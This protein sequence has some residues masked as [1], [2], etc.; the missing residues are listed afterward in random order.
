MIMAR[1]TTRR[2][3]VLAIASLLGLGVAIPLVVSIVT[4]IADAPRNDDWVY[5][6]LATDLAA[7]GVLSLRGVTTMLVGQL[8]VAQPFLWLFGI[9]PIAFAVAGACFATGAVGASYWLARL[10]VSPLRA[11]AAV[12]LLLV[13]PAYLA[14]ATSFMTDVPSIALQYVC[15]AT[16]V[17]ALRRS[18]IPNRWLLASAVSGCIAFSFREFAIV[19]PVAVLAAAIVAEPRRTTN[20][21]IGA[22]VIGACG[23][24]YLL[25]LSL[26]PVSV[27]ETLAAGGLLRS[28]FA[29][30]S[31]SVALLP[32]A[33][34]AAATWRDRLRRREMA[35]GVELGLVVVVVRVFQWLENGDVP[36]SLMSN[37]TSRWGAPEP[38]IVV[39]GRPLLFSGSTWLV[40]GILVL[41]ATVVVAAIGAG[42]VGVFVR[43]AAR[44]RAS[45][46]QSIGSPIGIL[47]LYA[48]GIV[49]GLTIYGINVVVFDRYY[50]SLVPVAA[51]LL[52]LKPA[53]TVRVPRGSSLSERADRSEP[54]R[55]A[56][57]IAVGLSLAGTLALSSAFGLNSYAFDSARWAAGER[58]VAAGIP[59]DAID[60][61]YEWVGYHQRE[62][63]QNGPGTNPQTIYDFWWP[64]RLRC[65]IVSSRPDAPSGARL[66]GTVSY[67]LFLVTGPDEVLYLF[68]AD[69]GGCPS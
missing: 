52:L 28:T 4:G 33:I 17:V 48:V 65:G 34:V 39:G 15:L 44:S 25:K 35:I 49:G 40:V 41:V 36:Q 50:W 53:M 61:G 19:A 14:Y 26:I 22:G 56:A 32:A 31:L 68:R 47:A 20:W 7:T 16:G 13:F 8:I 2:M 18:P 60:A 3:D 24:L 23:L 58:F 5:R 69:G 62:P 12:A 11:A 42:L 29:L 66:V 45:A 63:A 10:F 67:R 43:R 46:R 38:T 55:R 37:L 51:I 64:G 6:R 30:S 57:I 59:P 1:V 27:G 54:R 21:L 9:Q